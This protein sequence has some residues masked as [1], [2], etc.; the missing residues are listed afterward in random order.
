MPYNDLI[1]RGDAGADVPREVAQLITGDI[2]RMSAAMTLGRRVPTTTRDS[3]IPVL[4]DAPEAFWVAGDNGLKQT[5]KA[6]FA[7]QAIVAEE[8]AV[9]VPIPDNVVADSD[10]D[11][12]AAIE[13][14]LARAAA[15]K[16]DAAVIF[17]TDAPAS[18]PDSLAEEAAAATQTVGETTDPVVD[19]LGAAEILG[20]AGYSP[21]AAVVR[22]GWEFAAASNRA[23]SF[24]ANPVG[25]NS[26]LPLSIAGLGIFTRPVYF[27]DAGYQAIVAD[28]STVLIGLRQDLRVEFFNSGVVTDNLGAIVFNLLQQDMTVARMTMRVG[29]LLAKT[30][31][32][33]A[34]DT[35]GVPVAAVTTAAP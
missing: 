34:D 25:A 24:V 2:A 17:G 29:Y 4:V 10:F 6:D 35:P 30:V 21:T 26:P 16:I 8:L 22:H 33:L 7:R 15:R 12:W 20:T 13:P 3:R 18:W 19:L 23:D 32:N 5:S 31:T 14:L 11:L 1:D 9:I 27:D 28:W